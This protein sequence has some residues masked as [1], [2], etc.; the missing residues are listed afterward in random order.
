[1]IFLIELPLLLLTLPA[2]T[3]GILGMIVLY[4][5]L[6]SF[7]SYKKSKMQIHREAK[8]L[9]RFFSCLSIS[10]LLVIRF[11]QRWRFSGKVKYIAEKLGLEQRHFVLTIG[12]A[13]GIIAIFSMEILWDIF[14]SFGKNG[15]KSKNHIRVQTLHKWIRMQ[16]EKIAMCICIAAIVCIGIF[17]GCYIMQMLLFANYPA[18]YRDCALFK[19]VD[20]LASGYNPYTCN[21]LLQSEPPV[22]VDSGFINVL[23]SVIL[24]KLFRLPASLAIYITNLAYSVLIIFVT[25][26]IINNLNFSLGI[27]DKNIKVV[28]LCV[29]AWVLTFQQRATILVTRPD[30]FCCLVLLFII[31]LYTKPVFKIQSIYISSFLCVV[32]AFAKIHY[33]VIAVSVLVFFVCRKEKCRSLLY[34]L[35][36]S[37]SGI[38]FAILM[39]AATQYFFPTY[40]SEWIPR[41]IAMFTQNVSIEKASISVLIYKLKRMT[42]KLLPAIFII[43]YGYMKHFGLDN[44]R[45]FLSINIVVNFLV[46]LYTGRHDGAD[47]W[48][49]FVMLVPS[50]IL[51][52]ADT[53]SRLKVKEGV[54]LLACAFVLGGCCVNLAPIV[55]STAEVSSKADTFSKAYSL[56]REYESSEMYLSPVLSNYCIENKVYN[57]NYGDGFY[58]VDSIFADNLY[59][60]FPLSETLLPYTK[61]IYYQHEKYENEMLLKVKNREY[62]VIVLDRVDCIPYTIRDFFEKQ[63]EE[64]YEMIEELP[65]QYLTSETKLSFWIPK[66]EKNF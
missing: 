57:Y 2:N 1:M 50:V 15:E 23:P 52:A 25:K 28:M 7:L 60:K 5:I 6:C 39:F 45:T 22:V 59:E 12:I 17:F 44:N 48:Y 46:L 62:S 32:I 36:F 8:K 24:V 58:F 16:Y 13:F 55:K 65:I 35:Q 63:I 38:C 51:L 29:I 53:I 3:K 33:A 42:V 37:V 61:E 64:N 54:Y 41:I 27:K 19:L 56:L 4:G 26:R 9:L 11:V 34:L 21:A 18:E 10:V 40:L 30:I 49:F 43:L 66:G 14:V 31:D 20:D 47:L